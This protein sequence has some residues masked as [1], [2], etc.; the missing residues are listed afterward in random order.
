MPLVKIYLP[1]GKASEYKKGVGDGLHK[2]LVEVADVPEDDLF[3]L[4]FDMEPAN[5]IADPYYGNADR[6]PDQVVMEIT[7]N[8][9]RTVE[10]KKA[11]YAQIV[12]NLAKNPGIRSDDVMINLVEVPR[13]NWSFAH[14]IAM[15]AP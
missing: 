4:F 10:V 8:V 7:F 11:L 5:F 15:Y 12:K 1:K 9:G 14:G 6:S 2:A 3:Q 13:E